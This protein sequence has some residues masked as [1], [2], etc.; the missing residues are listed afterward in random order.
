[1]RLPGSPSQ[2]D[3]PEEVHS[4]MRKL[5]HFVNKFLSLCDLLS[6]EPQGLLATTLEEDEPEDEVDRHGEDGG[7]DNDRANELGPAGVLHPHFLALEEGGGGRERGSMIELS[8]IRCSDIHVC[9]VHV[10]V[11]E[12][13]GLEQAREDM[14]ESCF[15]LVSSW[16]TG[17]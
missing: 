8:N 9:N 13:G 14:M 12:S 10:H 7:E 1:M 15:E 16:Y 3:G 17:T 4:F 6:E 2:V 11:T 5:F